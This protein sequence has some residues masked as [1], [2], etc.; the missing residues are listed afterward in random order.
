MS[1]EVPTRGNARRKQI[2]ADPRSLWEDLLGGSWMAG[3]VLPGLQTHFPISGLP[4]WLSPSGQGT[5]VSDTQGRAVFGGPLQSPSVILS[6]PAAGRKII[7]PKKI[8]VCVFCS[9]PEGAG[10]IF[11]KRLLKIIPVCRA[12]PSL[13]QSLLHISCMCDN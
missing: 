7:L 3:L 4:A 12:G 11:A 8:Q 5:G 9:C 6:I 10:W 2:L 1:P 13:A